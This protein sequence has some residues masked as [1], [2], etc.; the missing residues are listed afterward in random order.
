[1]NEKIILSIIIPLFNAEKYI[2]DTLNSI[3]RQNGKNYEIIIIDDGSTDRSGII[4]DEFK[5]KYDWIVVVHIKN[6]GVSNARNTGL[7]IA[8]GEL[9]FFID[10]DD[11]VEPGFFDKVFENTRYDMVVFGAEFDNRINGKSVLH[12]ALPSNMERREKIAEYLSQMNRNTKDV[13]LNYLWNR[14]FKKS[15]IQK[16]NIVFKKDVKLGEDF[17]FI[18]EYISNCTS[19]L[20]TDYPIYRYIT[21]GNASLVSKF[22]ENEYQRRIMMQKAFIDLYNSFSVPESKRT[23]FYENEG[24][25]Y[26]ISMSKAF[27]PSCTFKTRKEK[28]EYISQ[29]LD[30]D[31]IKFIKCYIA[32]NK[33][34]TNTLIRISL[35]FRNKAVIYLC[36]CL[37][38]RKFKIWRRQ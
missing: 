28:I 17:I 9:I 21:R 27:R 30:E 38:C 32:K 34:K 18:T 25:N 26:I 10:S 23:A 20:V 7:R 19:I 15:I 3:I 24:A 33:S 11:I 6:G 1:M 16:N 37:I 31:G 14:L 2:A 22:D 4:A 29:F 13:F 5:Q 8:S 36:L 35:L 12:C